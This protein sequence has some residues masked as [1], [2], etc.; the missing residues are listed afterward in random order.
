MHPGSSRSSLMS[1][2]PR[3]TRARTLGPHFIGN[4]ETGPLR[5]P[6]P[7][8]R[9]RTSSRETRDSAGFRTRGR[10][11]EVSFEFS[12]PSSASASASAEMVLSEGGLIQT[13][14]GCRGGL[15]GSLGKR[16]GWASKAATSVWAPGD[17]FRHDVVLH[18]LG[19]DRLA[20]PV[21]P[22]VELGVGLLPMSPSTLRGKKGPQHR[23]DFLHLER[24]ALV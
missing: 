23:R 18:Q 19:S 2:M 21:A 10:R 11:Y 16:S 7:H 3:H 22:V 5:T 13:S 15:G 17:R 4:T 1:S 24:D 8:F 9:V 14:A 20:A 12:V 6:G